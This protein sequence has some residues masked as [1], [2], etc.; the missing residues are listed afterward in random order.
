MKKTLPP[1][2]STVFL[3]LALLALCT[4]VAIFSGFILSSI[5]SHWNEEFSKLTYLRLPAF[6]GYSVAVAGFFG[7]AIEAWKLL[8][9]FDRKKAFSKA[10]VRSLGRIK[11]FAF[12]VGVMLLGGIPVV[13][14]EADN[15][16]APGLI[17]FALAFAS[18]PIVVGVFAGVLQKILQNAISIKSENDL[19]V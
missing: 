9:Y 15:T 7:A 16:D 12:V 18:V 13:F 14:S 11:Y 2:V 1:H 6:V 3:R 8:N 4:L 5:Y 10:S 19:T 17:I